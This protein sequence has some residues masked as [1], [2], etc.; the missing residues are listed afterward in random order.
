MRMS[1]NGFLIDR[2]FCRNYWW[3]YFRQYIIP[4]YP[5]WIH[6]LSLSSCIFKHIFS[7]PSYLTSDRFLEFFYIFFRV[8][9]RPETFP[10]F[11]ENRIL[12]KLSGL[13]STFYS[14][15]HSHQKGIS[16][17]HVSN[18]KYSCF[19]D[20]SKWNKFFRKPLKEFISSFT[21]FCRLEVFYIVG[22]DE[23]WS[24]IAMSHSASRLIHRDNGNTSFRSQKY[25][26]RWIEFISFLSKWSEI[27]YEEW[28]ILNLLF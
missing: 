27:F 23:L 21:S 6:N 7:S 26:G 13:L 14:I 17:K 28:I 8:S 20:I 11:I 25:N 15:L 24:M 18:E 1:W 9:F 22:N 3:S 5:F 19:L 16:M 4:M 2:I 10:M 12:P